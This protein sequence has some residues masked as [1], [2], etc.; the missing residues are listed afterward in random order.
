MKAICTYCAGPKRQ[1]GPQLPAVRRYLSRRIDDLHK[2]ARQRRATFFILSG[3]Y[4][5]LLATDPIPWYDHLLQPDAVKALVP[6]VAAAMVFRW[7]FGLSGRAPVG[8]GYLSST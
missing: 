7:I 6:T 1:G 8:N 4:G 5:L 3:Q 2:L